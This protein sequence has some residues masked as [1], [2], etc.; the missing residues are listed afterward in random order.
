MSA[1]DQPSDQPTI[2]GFNPDHLPGEPL[3]RLLAVMACLRDPEKGCPWD[4]DQT[5]ATIA[6]H[7]IEE[8]YEVADAIARGDLEDLKGELGDLLFQVVYYARFAEEDG[9]YD[10]QDIAAAA[11]EKL[12]NR[13][14]HV[15]GDASIADADAQNQAWEARKQI[16]RSA[17][18]AAEGRVASVLDDVAVTLPAS[19]R[20]L[21]IGKRLARVGFDWPN[22]EEMI[23]KLLEELEELRKELPEADPD[24]LEDE[25]G[26]LLFAAVQLARMIGVDPD[27]AL[28]RTNAKVTQRFGYVER[29]LAETNRG[30]QDSSLEEMEA[31]WLEAKHS[32][33]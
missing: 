13:H 30:P 11:A 19:T 2:R 8:A 6:P 7:T 21:K 28:A 24:R 3:P 5:Y 22:P 23:A 31:L 17:R 1:S 9:L 29:R 18:A 16:E 12:I 33:R 32:E 4:L 26:D 15:F 25:T 27:Q 10:F 20:S 14:P